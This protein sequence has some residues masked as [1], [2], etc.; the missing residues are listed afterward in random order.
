[1]IVTPLFFNFFNFQ[2][3]NALVLSIGTALTNKLATLAL[4]IFT[5]AALTIITA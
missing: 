5:F 4:G 1:L 3:A 2:E